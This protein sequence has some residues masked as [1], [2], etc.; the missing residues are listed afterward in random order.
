MPFRSLR[1]S[2]EVLGE[3]L[4]RHRGYWLFLPVTVLMI[5][6]LLSP[7]PWRVEGLALLAIALALRFWAGAHVGAHTNGS[8]PEGPTLALTGPYAH[9][10]HPLYIANAMTALALMVSAN[11]LSWLGFA[12]LGLTVFFFFAALALAEE[13]ALLALHGDG[14]RQY[15]ERVPALGWRFL[16]QK[17][18]GLK[19][20]SDW[21]GSLKRQGRNA[22]YALALGFLFWLA[23]LWRPVFP[24]LQSPPMPV[25][26]RAEAFTP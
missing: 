24:H 5:S 15:C 18:G 16:P 6:R 25:P 7:A 1:K 8:K 10:R 20:R 21:P 17:K 13:K 23:A 12:A 4:F 19:S 2:G 9:T 26:T 14:F 22:F 11:S 3:R